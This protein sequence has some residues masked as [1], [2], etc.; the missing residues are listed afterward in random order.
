[1]RDDVLLYTSTENLRRE[2]GDT[3]DT[4]GTVRRD[5]APL[6]VVGKT[7]AVVPRL[8]QLGLREGGQGQGRGPLLWWHLRGGLVVVPPLPVR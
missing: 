2:E 4:R 8:T 3:R 7:M 5:R 6:A 1:M